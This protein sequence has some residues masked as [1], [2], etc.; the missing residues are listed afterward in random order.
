MQLFHAGYEPSLFQTA[1][2]I[3]RAFINEK[4]SQV[5]KQ[6]ARNHEH[7]TKTCMEI[8]DF[9]VFEDR[10][11]NSLQRDL[12]KMEHVRMRIAHEQVNSE[13]VD[14]ELIELKFIFDRCT[15]YFCLPGSLLTSQ[16]VHHDNRDFS[17][18]ANYQP[19][20]S[21]TFDQQTQF[22]EKSQGVRQRMYNTISACHSPVLS[23]A[24]LA[25]GVLEDLHQGVP[26]SQRS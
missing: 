6:T 18:L 2:L 24:R 13:L 9:I 16:L 26:A 3:V 14:M 25:L 20:N 11:D 4:Y 22:F 8:P 12:I 17:I 1:E 7:A 23:L 10:L 15:W 5:R 21:Q 19:R